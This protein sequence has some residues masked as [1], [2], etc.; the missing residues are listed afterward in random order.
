[1]GVDNGFFMAT[2]Q[3]KILKFKNNCQYFK[4]RTST[5]WWATHKTEEDGDVM[6][7]PCKPLEFIATK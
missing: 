4:N 1:M 5:E 7:T 6:W 3:L 2:D